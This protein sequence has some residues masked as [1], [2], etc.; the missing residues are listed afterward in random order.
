MEERQAIQV[1]AQINP[2]ASATADRRGSVRRA[3]DAKR[4]LILQMHVHGCSRAEIVRQLDREGVRRADGR[5]LTP[6]QLSSLITRCWI[7]HGE[8]D[9]AA[10]A[11]EPDARQ[12]AEPRSPNREGDSE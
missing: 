7:F 12:E 6:S 3:V 1:L 11:D 10:P 5:P 4:G 9:P 8:P 2:R